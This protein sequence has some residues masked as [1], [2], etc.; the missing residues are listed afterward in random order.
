MDSYSA[1]ADGLEK[2]GLLVEDTE[3]AARGHCVAS[4]LELS[5]LRIFVKS[6]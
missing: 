3:G 5:N 6:H 2:V 1:V 4:R